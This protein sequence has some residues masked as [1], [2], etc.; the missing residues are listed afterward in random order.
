LSQAAELYGQLGQLG[1]VG[2]LTKEI[3]RVE[4][5]KSFLSTTSSMPSKSSQPTIHATNSIQ[6]TEIPASTPSLITTI[7]PGP[8]AGTNIVFRELEKEANQLEVRIKNLVFEKNYPEVINVYKRLEE[9]YEKLNFS[10]QLRKIKFE[11]EKYQNMHSQANKQQIDEQKQ[12]EETK[13]GIAEERALRMRHEREVREA[14][15]RKKFEEAERLRKEK[16]ELLKVQRESTEDKVK[17]A[18]QERL[19]VFESKRTGMDI[20]HIKTENEE[21]KRKLIE[22]QKKKELEDAA[23]TDANN[24]M[25]QGKKSVVTRHYDDAL[26]FYGE[27]SKKFREIN[28]AQQAD[29]LDKELQNIKKLHQEYEE[30]LKREA[31]DRRKSQAEFDERARK[32]QAE[33]DAKKK[34]EEEERNKLSPEL[35]R[36]VETAQMTKEKAKELEEKQK[37]DKALARY[38]YLLEL[39]QELGSNII[40]ANDTI[41]I[42]QKIEELKKLVQ[43]TPQ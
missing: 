4:T 38:E 22:L 6:K 39:Y 40:S 7:S 31:E 34:R 20:D 26:Y 35:Q 14:D 27:A 32:L 41:V 21:R 25:E 9:I 17:R 36:K 13:L 23:V 29:M 8:S 15:E 16:E 30:K 12:Q 19:L 11:I 24:L 18:A 42:R 1:Q 5:L 33:Q 37:Y 10:F 28:W 2:I 43:T 3:K